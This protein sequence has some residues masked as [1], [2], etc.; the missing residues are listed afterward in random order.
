[1]RRY[2]ARRLLVAIPSL[3]IAS[4]IVFTLPRLVPGAVVALM[5]AEKAYARDLQAL[6]AKLGLD[7]PLHV[8]YLEWL[9]RTVRGNLGESLWTGRPVAEELARRLPVT[10]ELGILAIA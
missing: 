2:L 10:M 8:Q 4:F 1:M 9:G 3:L 6:C 5:R 7:R